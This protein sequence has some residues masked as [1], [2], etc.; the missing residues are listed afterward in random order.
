MF[1]PISWRKQAEKAARRTRYCELSEFSFS[2]ARIT[3]ETKAG[4][5]SAAPHAR[6]IATM[7]TSG[8]KHPQWVLLVHSS[9]ILAF[10]LVAFAPF[11]GARLSA[12]E[13]AAL[14]PPPFYPLYY[15]CKI[16]FL[17][18]RRVVGNISDEWEKAPAMGAFGTLV[19]YTRLSARG[20]RAFSR[21]SAERPR[22]CGY[23]TDKFSI[24]RNNADEWEKAPAMGAFGTLVGN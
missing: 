1:R 19:G 18:A 22:I 8:K 15:E 16:Y 20:V 5:I 23:V 10:R 17:Y 21:R 6:Y 7:P 13:P 2:T 12:P 24:H 3:T 4:V 9:G 14:P 11:Q